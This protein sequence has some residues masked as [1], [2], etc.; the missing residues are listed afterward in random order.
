MGKL[1][2]LNYMITKDQLN[3][4]FINKGI[5][6]Y[7]FILNIVYGGFEILKKTADEMITNVLKDNWLAFLFITILGYTIAIIIHLFLKFKENR[8]LFDK[9]YA[10]DVLKQKINNKYYDLAFSLMT[11]KLVGQ[12]EGNELKYIEH[13]KPEERKFLGIHSDTLG[14]MINDD[15]V[16]LFACDKKPELNQLINGFQ[17]DELKNLGFD[18]VE[19]D[20]IRKEI[21]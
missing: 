13:L 5:W 20:L 15:A 9:K 21:K 6:V 4:I 11:W 10:L 8:V 18:T 2:A 19:I 1:L 16:R 14:V 3:N 17:P 7:P 12:K